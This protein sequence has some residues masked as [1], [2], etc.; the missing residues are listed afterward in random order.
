VVPVAVIARLDT[1]TRDDG[2]RSRH[3]AIGFHKGSEKVREEWLAT[4]L[5]ER[6]GAKSTL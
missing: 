3:Q 1:F 4:P 5:T 2:E 6:A